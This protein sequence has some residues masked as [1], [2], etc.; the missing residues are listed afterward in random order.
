MRI[1]AGIRGELCSSLMLFKKK[2]IDALNRRSLQAHPHSPAIHDLARESRD[3][4]ALQHVALQGDIGYPVLGGWFWSLGLC[5]GWGRSLGDG[6]SEGLRFPV[7]DLDP[8]WRKGRD[9]GVSPAPA[10]WRCYGYPREQAGEPLN[11]SH[12]SQNRLAFSVGRRRWVGWGWRRRSGRLR[13][14]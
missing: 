3:S 5:G 13:R 1:A 7:S 2:D 11:S 8:H 14:G 6:L 10:M 4:C 12:L 9:V